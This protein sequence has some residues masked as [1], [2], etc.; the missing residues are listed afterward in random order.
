MGKIVI[1]MDEYCHV[2][3]GKYERQII[4]K[5]D[6]INNSNKLKQNLKPIYISNLNDLNKNK[7]VKQK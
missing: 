6:S 2:W 5:C 1:A 3:T 7:R 4:F